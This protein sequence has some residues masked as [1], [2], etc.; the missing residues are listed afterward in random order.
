[1]QVNHPNSFQGRFQTS[2]VLGKPSVALGNLWPLKTGTGKVL[3]LAKRESARKVHKNKVT[4]AL[5]VCFSS[6]TQVAVLIH[7]CYMASTSTPS[8]SVAAASSASAT[9][10]LT[11]ARTAI[12]TTFFDIIPEV[13]IHIYFG[14]IP[15]NHI[16]TAPC[17]S[18]SYP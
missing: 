18:F 13:S 17:D 4:T 8:T 5:L 10:T 16:G 11:T 14:T 12:E 7:I 2:E 6:L 3:Q 15:G 1:M 9:T